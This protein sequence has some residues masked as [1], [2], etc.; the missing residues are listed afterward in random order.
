MS[1]KLYEARNKIN[2]IDQQMKE[3][4]L[5]RME[6]VDE[7]IKEKKRLNLPIYDETREKEVIKKN[8]EDIDDELLKTCYINFL[9]SLMNES[10]K[11]QKEK[12]N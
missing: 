7:I 6:I 2:V 9:I 12:L 1:D 8:S 10:K 3:L 4:F 11:Y 5:K